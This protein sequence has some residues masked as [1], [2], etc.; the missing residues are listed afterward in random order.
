MRFKTW[1]FNTDVKLPL[2]QRLAFQG[3]MFTGS[4]LSNILGGVVQGVCP[5]VRVPIR[6]TGGW[7][8]L[9]Y[10][11]NSCMTTNVGVGIDDPRDADS[12]M[13]RTY[14]RVVY[15]NLFVDVT[16][17]LQTGFELSS[18]RTSYHNRTNEPGFTPINTPSAPGKANVVEWTVRYHF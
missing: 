1:S 14:N 15:A 5:C 8:E 11:L 7:G 10:T 9:S 13:G 3:E 4:N 12:L 16:D 2:T 17:N 6:S 18:W